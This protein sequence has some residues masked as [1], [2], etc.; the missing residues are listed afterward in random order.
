MSANEDFVGFVTAEFR[1]RNKDI[2]PSW[3]YLRNE[4]RQNMIA[5]EQDSQNRTARTEQPEKD[6]GPGSSGH[7]NIP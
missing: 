3:N 1:L 2:I 5:I 7:G 6:I 4:D